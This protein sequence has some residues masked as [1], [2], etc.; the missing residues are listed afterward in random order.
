MSVA[1]RVALLLCLVP[2]VSY[3]VGD[4]ISYYDIENNN[5]WLDLGAKVYCGE[6]EI[7]KSCDVNNTVNIM[8]ATYSCYSSDNSSSEGSGGG[9]G[10]GL[11]HGN[12]PG[13]GRDNASVLM[14]ILICAEIVML[15]YNC[16]C[17]NLTCLTNFNC[18]TSISM[19]STTTV[20]P[21]STT[22][23]GHITTV[24]SLMSTGETST[25]FPT[26]S[27]TV[28]AIIINESTTTADS[29]DS[30]QSTLNSGSPPS[31]DTT[32]SSSTESQLANNMLTL[33][34]WI[35]LGCLIA[36]IIVT[37]C[38]IFGVSVAHCRRYKSKPY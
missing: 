21:T 19:T 4:E 26:A 33:V 37:L 14:D 13:S 11:G 28:Q 16:S 36:L 2:F 15:P 3:S 38:A 18:T 23:I 24:S 25:S 10:N 22:T 6:V 27:T 8:K 7:N 30:V 12:G 17:S 31:S 32:A 9:G 1:N 29:T 20:S 35:V 5:D 34:L